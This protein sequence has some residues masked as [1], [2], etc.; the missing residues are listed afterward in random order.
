MLTDPVDV[1]QF[2]VPADLAYREMTTRAVETACKIAQTK[3]ARLTASFTH[4]LVSAIAEAFSNVVIH[5]YE[6]QARGDVVLRLWNYPDRLEI[7]LQDH[8]I[9]FDP[10]GVPEPVMETLP[11]S[12]MGVFIIQSFVDELLYTPGSPNR[13]VLVK[14]FA[15]PQERAPARTD[16]TRPPARPTTSRRNPARTSVSPPPPRTPGASAPP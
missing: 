14:Y 5:A 13:M 16:T 12:G 8:G 2:S 6:G 3:N 10:N 1:I 4:E 9:S 15:D 7:E 11:E